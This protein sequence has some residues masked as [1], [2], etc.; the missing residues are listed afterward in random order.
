LI[1]LC[2]VCLLQWGQCFFSSMRPVVLRRFFM[3]VYRDTP[4]DRLSGLLRHSV[5]S[6]VIIMRTP[7]FLAMVFVGKR[8]VSLLHNSLSQSKSNFAKGVAGG[9]AIAYDSSN[10]ISGSGRA[11]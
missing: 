5:H 3:V 4:G 6:R 10:F 2:T 1:S 8:K 7:L 11:A 9:Q